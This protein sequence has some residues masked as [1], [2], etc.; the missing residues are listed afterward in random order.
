MIF[1]LVY[2]SAPHGSRAFFYTQNLFIP[3][4]TEGEGKITLVD[5]R[6][7]VNL[8]KILENF[9]NLGE[10]LEILSYLS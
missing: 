6:N 7:F 1:K 8:E 5:F 9:G 3:F 2:C 10:I 4:Q